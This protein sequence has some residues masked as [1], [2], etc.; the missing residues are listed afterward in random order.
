[1]T[2]DYHQKH[3]AVSMGAV[4][5]PVLTSF[6]EELL[7]KKGEVLLTARSGSM[8]PLI[9]IG[10]KVKVRTTSAEAVVFGDIIVFREEEKLV[11]HRV[12]AKGKFDSQTFFLQKGD[13]SSSPFRIP[14]ERVL[15]K[16]FEIHKPSRCILL[17][18]RKGRFLNLLLAVHS[19]LTCFIQPNLPAKER[20]LLGN[21]K[22]QFLHC[23][24]NFLIFPLRFGQRLR[25][26][27]RKKP[28]VL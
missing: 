25:M 27:R 23:V 13:R 18:N 24:F 7:L 8:A 17:N 14:A 21:R 9:R 6:Y 3:D 15:G 19:Y 2:E 26:N 11:V 28:L 16:V 20:A 10:D 1:M 5:P 22:Y 4:S 12:V